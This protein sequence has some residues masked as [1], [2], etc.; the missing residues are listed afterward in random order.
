MSNDIFYS[1]L[2]SHEDG[3][4]AKASTAY[5]LACK[6][7]EAYGLRVSGT[8][9]P[10]YSDEVGTGINMCN[11]AGWPVLSLRVGNIKRG[12]KDM[13][14]GVCMYLHSNCESSQ[15]EI[16]MKSV[17]PMY[18]S[19][20]IAKEGTSQQKLFQRKLNSMSKAGVCT[21]ISMA[22]EYAERTS[23]EKINA[24]WSLTPLD[25]IAL[26]KVFSGK[27]AMAD[28]DN[29]TV[30]RIITAYEAYENRTDSTAIVRSEIDELFGREKWLIIKLNGETD[31]IVG[32]LNTSWAIPYAVSK[33]KGQP[34]TT[35][36]DV[37]YS[38]ITFTVPFRRYKSLDVIDP[39]YRE[40]VMASLAMAKLAREGVSGAYDTEQGF[41]PIEQTTKSWMFAGMSVCRWSSKGHTHLLVD[42]V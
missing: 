4:R 9:R 17:K 39:A 27:L 14:D 34:N 13:G 2:V 20:R 30:S 35:T 25:Q 40:D 7:A 28:V 3:R 29:A 1:G 15:I 42:K 19:S 11:E 16:F 33:L 32:A 5:P 26:M 22:G 18:M 37:D 12:N 41:F 31:V 8:V 23:A 38:K 24:S 36:R 21:V 6:L 10:N